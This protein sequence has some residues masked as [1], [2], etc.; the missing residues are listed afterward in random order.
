MRPTNR[1]QHRQHSSTQCTNTRV[2]CTCHQAES[3]KYRRGPGTLHLSPGLGKQ[4]NLRLRYET[5][6]QTRFHRYPDRLAGRWS[7]T[8]HSCIDSSRTDQSTNTPTGT[9]S[10]VQEHP[11][12]KLF[13]LHLVVQ[14]WNP[15]KLSALCSQSMNLRPRLNA[16]RWRFNP[17]PQSRTRPPGSESSTDN[18]RR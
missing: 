15:K 13:Q 1:E 10:R 17:H 6:C 18:R 5:R 3:R 2:S 12:D 9:R 4:S 7:K 11:R 16:F 14:K 8:N